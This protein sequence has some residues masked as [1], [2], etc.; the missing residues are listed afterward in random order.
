[1]TRKNL[2][3]LKILRDVKEV[4]HLKLL[5]RGEYDALLEAG[6]V[7]G[8][9]HGDPQE[10]FERVIVPEFRKTDGE[11]WKRY[12][13][14]EQKRSSSQHSVVSSAKKRRFVVYGGENILDR[15]CAAFVDEFGVSTFDWVS[16]YPEDRKRMLQFI[17]KGVVAD[18]FLLDDA[19]LAYSESSW[20]DIYYRLGY[21]VELLCGKAHPGDREYFPGLLPSL[22]LEIVHRWKKGR[23]SKSPFSDT[24]EV[25]RE[26]KRQFLIQGFRLEKLR[27]EKT[28]SYSTYVVGFREFKDLSCW[29]TKQS[30]IGARIRQKSKRKVPVR[31]S[32]V[33]RG[34]NGKS[35]HPSLF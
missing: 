5:Y 17:V 25:R 27:R 13:E 15:L 3:D 16:G 18:L 19:Y 10:A 14:K 34:K 1:M 22:G 30:R 11:M 8:K 26:L 33:M 7:R 29:S 24:T 4:V 31:K 35:D 12:F 2:K 6:Y 20:P 28:E 21:V 23:Q 32:S 9:D